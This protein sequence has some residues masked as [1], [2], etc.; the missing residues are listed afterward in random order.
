MDEF[1]KLFYLG[2]EEFLAGTTIKQLS[3]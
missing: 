3:L 1:F 2:I